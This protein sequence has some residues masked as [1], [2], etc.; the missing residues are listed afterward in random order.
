MAKQSKADMTNED[1][2]RIIQQSIHEL[3]DEN[4][5]EHA[6]TRADHAEL[7]VEN[8][9]EHTEMRTMIENKVEYGEVVRQPDFDRLEER[10]TILELKR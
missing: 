1:L 5:R 10:V 7:R 3:R 6:K 4:A 9:R 8:T 2:A